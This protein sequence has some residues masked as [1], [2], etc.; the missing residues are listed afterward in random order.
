[1]TTTE[2]AMSGPEWCLVRDEY[3]QAGIVVD[4]TFA[5]Q[6]MIIDRAPMRDAGAPSNVRNRYQVIVGNP[7]TSLTHLFRSKRQAVEFARWTRR[8]E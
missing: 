2:R 6:T 7:E 3:Q 8:P 4:S 5:N 1:M